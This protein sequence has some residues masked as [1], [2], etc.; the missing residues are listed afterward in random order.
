MPSRVEFSSNV[1]K[2]AYQ[3]T[4]KEKTEITDPVDALEHAN[5]E[6]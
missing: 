4:D 6:V 1:W 3:L 5:T 2:K